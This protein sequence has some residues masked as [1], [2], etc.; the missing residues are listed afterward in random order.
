MKHLLTIAFIS[1]FF[2]SFGQ[3]NMFWNN[4]SNFNPA[5]SGFQYD[6]HAFGTYTDYFPGLS[7]NYKSAQVN[8]GANF[9]DHHGVGINYSGNYFPEMS[10]K[11]RL[12]YNYQFDLKKA[13]N[14]SI[15]SGLGFGRYELRKPYVN[16]YD[17]INFPEPQ[18]RLELSFGAAYSW[19]N[20]Y[21]GISI[22]DLAAKQSATSFY[23]A[24]RMGLNLHAAYQFRVGKR[25]LL[26]PRAIYSW[27]DGFQGL[28]FNLTTTFNNK[29]SLGISSEARDSFGVNIGWDI[30]SKFRVA[31][32]Y[33]VTISKL[34]NGVSGGIHSFSIGYFLKSKPRLKNTRTLE[35]NF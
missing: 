25:F 28:R 13:G 35:P 23:Q 22:T 16:F 32:M 31:Y 19:K 14:L 12:N 21:A 15:G 33:N 26:I 8:F 2:F 17:S 3:T 10:N 24:P 5:M 30:K 18:N 7:G 34:Y 20:L 1:T 6:V 27:T 11:I 4:Y 9:A 29:F